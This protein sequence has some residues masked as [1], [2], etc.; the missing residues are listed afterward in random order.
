VIFAADL[1][2]QQKRPVKMKEI[3]QKGTK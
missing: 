1:S 3:Q 2:W